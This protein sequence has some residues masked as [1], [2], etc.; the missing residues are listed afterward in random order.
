MTLQGKLLFQAPGRKSS[1]FPPFSRRR[2]LQIPFSS[3]TFPPP[4]LQR[5][6]AL[7]P[8]VALREMLFPSLTLAA[9]E[10]RLAGEDNPPF[11]DFLVDYRNF[12][13]L[14]PG[15]NVSPS[16]KVLLFPIPSP[17]RRRIIQGTK[18]PQESWIFFRNASSPGNFPFPRF[19]YPF[20]EA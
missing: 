11:R 13:S 6:R 20:I 14:S 2:H 7:Y 4:F 15:E 17:P 19:F 16:R 8:P 1:L 10:D 3:F 12:P 5:L 18:K 9:S